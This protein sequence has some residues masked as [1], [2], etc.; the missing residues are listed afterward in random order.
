[1]V[2]GILRFGDHLKAARSVNVSHSGDNGPLFRADSEYLLHEWD[3]GVHLEKLAH[4][5]AQDGRCKGKKRL[6]PLD[7]GVQDVLHIRAAREDS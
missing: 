2:E 4:R 1:M 7:L 5:L 6:P 3:I